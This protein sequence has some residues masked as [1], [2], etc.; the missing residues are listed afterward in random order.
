MGFNTLTLLLA[1]AAAG[2]GAHQKWGISRI[3]FTNLPDKIH[4]SNKTT[5]TG[6]VN[7]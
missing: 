6:V 5:S 2:S 7:K 4:N 1:A 3:K